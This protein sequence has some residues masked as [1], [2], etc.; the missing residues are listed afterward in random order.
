MFHI[1]YDIIVQTHSQFMPSAIGNV[2]SF[3]ELSAGSTD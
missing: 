1:T 2:R 3:P